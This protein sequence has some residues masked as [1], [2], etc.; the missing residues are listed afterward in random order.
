MMK[1]K[2]TGN[3]CTKNLTKQKVYICDLSCA[4]MT[5]RARVCVCV[6]VC[7]CVR[8][9]VGMCMCVFGVVSVAVTSNEFIPFPF[10]SL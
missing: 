6:H 2:K 3:L 4:C 9:S 10:E 5:I 8:A 1:K 7:V